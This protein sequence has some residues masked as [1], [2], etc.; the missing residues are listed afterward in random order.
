MLTSWPV[1]EELIIMKGGWAMQTCPG[2]GFPSL[3]WMWSPYRDLVIIILEEEMAC[4]H[5]FVT[6]WLHGS[7]RN[8]LERRTDEG[9][10]MRLGKTVRFRT[11]PPCRFFPFFSPPSHP[12]KGLQIRVCYRQR[13]ELLSRVSFCHFPHLWA[14][15]Y[16]FI[17]VF[18]MICKVV[19]SC[20]C[21]EF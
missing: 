9:K 13:W 16:W 5:R 1:K 10:V 7:L 2:F 3:L 11:L 4:I 8:Q 18:P 21:I 6:T 20:S 17:L 12:P 15:F 19:I 14:K